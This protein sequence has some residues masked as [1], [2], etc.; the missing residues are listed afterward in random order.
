M[1]HDTAQMY[2]LN[3]YIRPYS[4]GRVITLDDLDYVCY[5]SAVGIGG[6]PADAASWSCECLTSP[7]D[8]SCASRNVGTTLYYTGIIFDTGIVIVLASYV[9]PQSPFMLCCSC[10]SLKAGVAIA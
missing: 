10:P 5:S 1:E 2:W 3:A 8:V 6:H 9:Y 7:R 4:G